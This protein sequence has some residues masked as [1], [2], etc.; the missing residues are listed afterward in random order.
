MDFPQNL[1]MYPPGVIP[2]KNLHPP[3]ATLSSSQQVGEVA[4]KYELVPSHGRQ[5]LS[6]PGLGAASNGLAAAPVTLVKHSR[7][8]DGEVG[9]L[10]RGY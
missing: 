6:P 4:L 8:E 9:V 5:Q 1:D 10:S 3:Q 7:E 2:P